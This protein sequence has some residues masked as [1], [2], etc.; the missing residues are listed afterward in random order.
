MRH[1]IIRPLAA[2]A[3]AAAALVAAA[4]AFAQ[5]VDACY[6]LRDGQRDTPIG[7]FVRVMTRPVAAFKRSSPAQTMHEMHG[8]LTIRTGRTVGG[9]PEV[10][11][12]IVTGSILVVTGNGAQMSLFRNFGRGSQTL[13][14][15]SVLDCGTKRDAPV[16]AKWM[17]RGVTGSDSD[18]FARAILGAREL[19]LRKVPIKTDGCD[20]FT[21]RPD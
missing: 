3:L 6:E 7:G 4:P 2:C 21:M 8:R 19:I 14:G 1:D 18:Q 9:R 10:E 20:D 16:A 15:F 5:T 17:C 13:N 11:M 12:D